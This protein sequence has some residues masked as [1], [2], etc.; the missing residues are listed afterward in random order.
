[1]F[2][3][4][5]MMSPMTM[6]YGM[7]QGNVH[8]SFKARYGVGPDIWGEGARPDYFEC[9]YTPRRALPEPPQ[10]NGFFKRIFNAWFK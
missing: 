1:M 4:S 8:Q 10:A 2:N 9:S 5:M 7:N 6:G 3:Y